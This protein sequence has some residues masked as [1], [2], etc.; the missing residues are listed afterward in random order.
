MRN[1]S[2]HPYT[3][4]MHP[5]EVLEAVQRRS[6]SSVETGQSPNVQ[7]NFG[8]RSPSDLIELSVECDR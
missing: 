7:D 1:R 8:E 6:P 5:D 3:P 4:T 2:D